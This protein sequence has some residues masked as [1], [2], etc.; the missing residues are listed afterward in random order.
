MKFSILIP[1]LPS[2]AG[3]FLP[4][5]LD[6]LHPQMDGKPIELLVLM[7]NKKRSVG[8]KRNELLS[9]AQGEYL[10]FIDDDDYV[11]GDYCDKLLAAMETS[12]DCIVFEQHVSINNSTPKRCIYGIGLE[13][14]DSPELWTGKPAH[15]MCWK[16]EIAKRH[17]FPDKT[18]G[19]DTGWVAKA[20][21]DIK[22][23]VRIDKPLYFYEFNS[24]TTETRKKR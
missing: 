22:N 6:I 1:S 12:P 14:T 2:R 21:P 11:S 18:Y 24:A 7:D 5:L 15:T 3:F 17:S 16:S 8:A 23:E 20:W 19:E 9:L 10:S 13:Y 4:R